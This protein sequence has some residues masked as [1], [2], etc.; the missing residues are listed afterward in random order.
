MVRK[1][2]GKKALPKPK[3]VQSSES[4]VPTVISPHAIPHSR[5]FVRTDH[6][7]CG[8]RMQEEEAKRE[9]AIVLGKGCSEAHDEM[10]SELLGK[11]FFLDPEG[12]G[13][14][15]NTAVGGT[16]MCYPGKYSSTKRSKNLVYV[17]EDG[18]V[19]VRGRWNTCADPTFC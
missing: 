1:G 8:W 11:K 9:L 5:A 2:I 17:R 15:G 14:M 13:S 6:H 7:C 12:S 19:K 10:V 4:T 3:A 18:R 16:N